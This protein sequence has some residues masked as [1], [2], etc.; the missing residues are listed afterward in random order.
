M[1][2]LASLSRLAPLPRLARP[3]SFRRLVRGALAASVLVAAG[4]GCAGDDTVLVGDMAVPSEL[5]GRW[6]TPAEAQQPTGS[7]TNALTFGRDGRFVAEWRAAGVY[8]GQ[9]AAE[10]SAYSRSYGTYQVE[11]ARLGMRVD[12]TVTWDRFYGADAKETVTRP[13][14]YGRMYDDARFQVDGDTLVLDYTTYPAD[15]PVATRQTFRRP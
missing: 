2:L 1:G 9:P 13:Q 15:A 7:H 8:P 12:S 6:E 5:L 14:P 11:G 10:P 4:T 3:V